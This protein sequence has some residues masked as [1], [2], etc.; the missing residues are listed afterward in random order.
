MTDTRPRIAVVILAAGFSSRMGALKPLLPFGA[1]TVLG[2]VVA[3]CHAAGLNDVHVVVGHEGD[4]VAAEAARYGA[5]VTRN[6]DYATGMFSSVRAGIAALPP[7]IAG[8]LILPVDVPL[9]RAATLRRLADAARRDRPT[10]LHPIFATRRGHPPYVGRALFA[11]IAAAE[12]ASGLR[13]V[14][15]RHAGCTSECVVF[16][17]GILL[18]MD[19]P[20]DHAALR[21]LAARHAVPDDGECAALLVAAGAKV[22]IRRHGEAVAALATALAERLAAAGVDLDVDRVR[23]AA[24]LHDIAKGAPRHAEAGAAFLAEA[25]FADL[26]DIVA[27]HMECEAGGAPSAAQ[28][29]F[30]ADKLVAGTRPTT[31]AARF[32]PAEARFAADPAALAGARRRHV[33]AEAILAAIAAR[34]PIA[35]LLVAPEQ[36]IA[37]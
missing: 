29:V 17:R 1:N 32:A 13:A 10:I 15:D 11:E 8:T 36:R 9:V 24:L 34:V 30:L 33:A 6:A 26:A 7:T 25:G 28:V 22:D 5:A 35:D 20:A 19:F 3:T 23:A 16:D 4:A 14:L 2:H 18:D 31:L 27:Q 12:G 37:G 21:A